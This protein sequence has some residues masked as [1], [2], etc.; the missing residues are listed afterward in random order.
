MKLRRSSIRINLP[1]SPQGV[2]PH[3]HQAPDSSDMVN[4]IRTW[5]MAL[6]EIAEDGSNVRCLQSGSSTRLRPYLAFYD[7]GTEISNRGRD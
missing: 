3:L 5:A 6:R 2:G 1:D 7:V 4:E